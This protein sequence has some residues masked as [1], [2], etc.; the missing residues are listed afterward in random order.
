MQNEDVSI[1]TMNSY[2]RSSSAESLREHR[3]K[4][5][6]SELVL[7]VK[8]AGEDKPQDFL[9]LSHFSP[10]DLIMVNFYPLS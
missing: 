9:I 10:N 8:E 2:L 3:S 6:D 1:Q 5:N 7:N 4:A